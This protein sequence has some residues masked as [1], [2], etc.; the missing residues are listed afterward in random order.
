MDSDDLL[1]IDTNGRAVARL[2]AK[3]LKNNFAAIQALVPGQSILPMIKANA[4]GHG[5]TWA[6]RELMGLPGLYAFGVAS[7]DEGK[8]LRQEL[9]L[10]ARKAR[11]IVFTGA[12]P[13]TEEKGRFCESY[14]LTP[15]LQTDADWQT[16]LKAG[17]PGKLPYELMFNT[18]MNRLGLSPGLASSIAK[19]L[20]NG[21]SESFPEGVS[22]HLAMAESPESKLSQMQ[23]G[24]F[25]SIRNE[26]S[27]ALPSTQFHAANSAGIWNQKQFGFQAAAKTDAVRPGLSLYGIVPWKGAPLRGLEPVMSFEAKLLQVSQLRVGESVGYGGTFKAKEATRLGTLGAGYG[28]GLSRALSNRGWVSL[29]GE[30]CALIGR[31]S[32]DLSA[33]RVPLSARVG[34]WAQLMGA[35]IDP[36]ELAEVAGTIPYEIL[37]SVSSR[38]QRIYG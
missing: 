25:T 24:I 23:V 9:G 8:T 12:T 31:V 19:T 30:K 15:M 17:W 5:A 2:S 14:G 26:L 7:L 22:T 1:D 11:I 4:Y 6:A 29:R 32:M 20:R 36:W 33:I 35:E 3:A 34:D 10:R 38:V 37:T 18:G 16:F 13:W 27:P 21:P 28:D